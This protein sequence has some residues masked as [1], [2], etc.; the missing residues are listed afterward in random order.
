MIPLLDLR[1][2]YLELKAEIDLTS[3]RIL[4]SG[5]YI[6][7]EEVEAFEKEFAAYCEAKHCIGV[8]NGLDALHLILRALKVGPGDE[9][10]VPANTFIATWLAVTHTGAIPVP[11]EPDEHTFNLDP[12]RLEAALTP[13]TRVIIPVH[14][15]GQPADM[16]PILEIAYRHN[17]TV[18]EDAAQAHGARY[19][20]RRI[21]SISDA[22][23][24]SFYPTKNLGAF[25]DAGAVVT[26]ND[27]LADSIR[28]FRNY[29]SKEKYYNEIR[30]F[31]SRLDPLQAG[32]LRVKLKYLDEWNHRRDLVAAR[33]LNELSEVKDLILPSI[34]EWAQPVWYAFVVRYPQRNQLEQALKKS[35]IGTIIHYPVPPHL[36][37]AYVDGGW[38]VGGLP[39]T[40]NLSNSVLSLPIGPH[41]AN[42]D[43]AK[44]I[45]T[46]QS[47]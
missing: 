10:I 17:I 25:G 46:I 1:A 23:A 33:Y 35:D 7:G 29:G 43:V 34:P 13:Q 15:Y 22:T 30:G 14:L 32:V 6:L 8:G 4:D 26:N 2:T 47:L 36:S 9:V 28:L 24:F 45:E 5:R 44:V 16:D 40:E 19:K 39:I 18:I 21:G 37:E 31:N 12:N 42:E 3:H 38:R 41:L 27:N 11:V 20:S